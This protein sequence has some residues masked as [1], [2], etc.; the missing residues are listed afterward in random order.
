MK[1]IINE[2]KV[3]KYRKIGSAFLYGTFAF[4]AIGVILTFN[5]D[6]S[7]YMTAYFLTLFLALIASQVGVYLTNHYGGNPRQDE[8]LNAALKGLDDRYRIY[9][10]NAGTNHLLLGPSGLQILI[11]YMQTGSFTYNEEKQR[12]QQKGT[13]KFLK[14][15]GREGLGRPDLDI[16]DFTRDVEK[17]FN[18]KLGKEL[19][20]PVETV[21]VF[22]NPQA[23][24]QAL[25]APTPTLHFSKLKDFIR[26]KSKETALAD[27]KIKE[28]AAVLP[29]E[30]TE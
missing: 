6:I 5:Q 13:N 2:K 22:T 19:D 3:K 17:Y 25:N 14:F 21:L 4:L 9:H 7:K 30:E 16:K 24:V 28:L 12:W 26:R 18:K 20:V 10:F 1:I 27:E 29:L 15:F 23:E 8:A 11:P